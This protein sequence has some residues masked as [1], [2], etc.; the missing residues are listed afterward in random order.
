MTPQNST[1]NEVEE[2]SLQ[3]VAAKVWGRKWLV[4]V[5]TTL[6]T[7]AAMTIA[8]LS[9]SRY[10]ASVLLS[11]V[12]SEADASKLGGAGALL[13]QLGG[14][15][16]LSSLAG[17]SSSK[18]AEA[19]ATLQS[20]LLTEAF[21]TEKNL[22]PVLYA[23][24]WDADNIQWKTNGGKAQ[25]TIW[26]AEEYFRLTIRKILEDKKTGLVTL[27]M[28]WTDPQLAADWANEVIQRTNSYLRSKTIAESERNLS[29]LHEQLKSTSIVELQN[30]ISGLIEA[31]I[32]KVMIAKGSEEFAFRVIDPARVPERRVSPKRM[33]I[34]ATGFFIGFVISLALALALP[35]KRYT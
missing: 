10:E 12:V 23:Q 9:P 20:R 35:A 19:V 25:P 27:T 32:K 18:R 6:F 33:V 17:T 29:Y 16:G 21:I 13:S 22:L 34:T 1:N 24:Q 30:A 2:I 8:L 11:P 26:Q 31:E 3:D 7:A 5:M 14:L 28:T 4:A 15:G